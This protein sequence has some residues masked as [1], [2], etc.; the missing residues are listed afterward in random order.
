[1]NKI[2]VISDIHFGK[3]KKS[4]N[5]PDYIRIDS[6]TA[7]KE[8]DNISKYL[9]TDIDLSIQMGDLVRNSNDPTIDKNNYKKI[10][11]VLNNFNPNL[12]TIEGNHDFEITH[13]N[14]TDINKI[15][16]DTLSIIIINPNNLFKLS[17]LEIEKICSLMINTEKPM[18]VFT[19]IPVFPIDNKDNFLFGNDSNQ[20]LV[21]FDEIKKNIKQ[22]Q[23]VFFISGHFH[24]I[25]NTEISENIKQITLPSFSENIVTSPTINAH[26][27]VYTIIESDT[28]TLRIK[29]YS[30]EFCFGS[31]E[32]KLK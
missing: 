1:M 21:N 5:H 22:N 30:R 29:S 9:P 25:S 12:M 18:L 14:K 3:L 15:E 31:Q 28:N 16:L 4:S 19:H 24:W 17:S 10:K 26:P 27:C 2:F 13:K 32:F 6:E 20:H 8:I 7:D 11:Q 23:K